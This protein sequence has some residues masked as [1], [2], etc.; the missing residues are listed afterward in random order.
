MT[1]ISICSFGSGN[2]IAIVFSGMLF[3]LPGSGFKFDKGGSSP[4]EISLIIEWDIPFG[5]P[6]FCK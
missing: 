5:S 3:S 2:P 4:V 1:V 6:A